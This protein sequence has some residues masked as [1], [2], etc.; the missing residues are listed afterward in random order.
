MEH[1]VWSR[2]IRF[3]CLEIERIRQKRML[4]VAA[5]HLSWLP[6]VSRA[7]AGGSARDEGEDGIVKS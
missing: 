1:D 7:L 3:V 6:R 4:R 5:A 2:S